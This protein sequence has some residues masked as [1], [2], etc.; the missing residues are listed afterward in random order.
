[1][2]DGSPEGVKRHPNDFDPLLRA[3]GGIGEQSQRAESE[4]RCHGASTV[5]SRAADAEQ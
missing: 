4:E 2:L 3:E 1:V 5:K